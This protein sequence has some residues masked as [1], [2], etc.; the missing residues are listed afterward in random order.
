MVARLVK[1][2]PNYE[3]LLGRASF[4]NPKPVKLIKIITDLI[5][6]GDDIIL[7]FFSGSATTAHAVMDLNAEDGGKRRCISIQIPESCDAGSEA[8]RAGYTTIADIGK[9]RIRRVAQ[10]IREHNQAADLD[11]GLRVFK[12]ARSNF[13]R[14]QSPTERTTA[15]W[16]RATEQMTLPLSATDSEAM[17]FE[18]MLAEGY[19]PDSAIMEVEARG[20]A[21]YTVAHPDDN[22]VIHVC[23]DTKLADRI[24]ETLGIG[25]GDTFI[26][27]DD[28]LDD[29]IAVNLALRCNV[30]VVM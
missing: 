18:I 29:V 1:P 27:R 28:A 4:D 22:R 9:E 3:H 14:W 30:K 17:L 25:E 6:S 7:D 5:T 26:C 23:L 12:L 20:N 19:P 24:P 11:L 10:K 13:Q 2:T 8:Y 21:I 16:R 15:E